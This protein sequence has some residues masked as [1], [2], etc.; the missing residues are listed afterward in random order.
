MHGPINIRNRR[1]YKDKVQK[2]DKF[3]QQQQ[4]QQQQNALQNYY[5]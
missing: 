4:Q 3:E 2:V 5:A 1:K